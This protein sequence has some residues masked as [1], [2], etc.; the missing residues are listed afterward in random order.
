M[1][2]GPPDTKGYLQNGHE[3]A[4]DT[5]DIF[6]HRSKGQEAATQ[7]LPNWP[8]ANSYGDHLVNK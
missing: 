8:L 2:K 7:N 5:E 4:L 3:T 1:E 6:M